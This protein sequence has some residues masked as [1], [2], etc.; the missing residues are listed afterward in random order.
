MTDN[1][2][3]TLTIFLSTLLLLGAVQGSAFAFDMNGF[4]TGMSYT[5]VLTHLQEMNY[6]KIQE[7]GKSIH[8]Y[9]ADRLVNFNFCKQKLVGYQ[10]EYEASSKN[11]IVLVDEYIKRFGTANKMSTDIRLK[12]L[13]QVSSLTMYWKSE[14]D[15]Y[16]ISYTVFPTNDNLN[17]Y[18]ESKNSCW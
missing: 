4:K 5:D 13:G 10:V 3:R 9:A 11:Y 1:M 16:Q 12:Q 17:L 15:S 2:A 8:A 18:V 7:E 6:K 14:D